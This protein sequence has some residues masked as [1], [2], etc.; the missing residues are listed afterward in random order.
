MDSSQLYYKC[1]RT[2]LVRHI[3]QGR[4]RILDV[5]CAEGF[6]GQNL[7]QLGLASEVVGIEYV[8]D[9]AKSA[10]SKLDRV[11]C[12]DIELMNRDEMGLEAES[13]DYIIC[14][15]VLEHLRDPWSVLSWLV[16]RLK[17]GG[18]VIASLP[19]VRH[20]SVL[21]PLLLKGE[22]EYQSRGIMDRTHLRFFTRKSSV[23]LIKQSGL[24]IETCEA[25]SYRKLD[26]LILG[27]TFG[28]LEGFTAIQWLITA[29]KGII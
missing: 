27:I 8:S 17:P 13:F 5:G 11:I 1:Q 16:T 2:E 26:K 24:T 21:L 28:R 7:R 6:L 15:D 29:K 3:R 22:W 12:G 9:A 23:D 4:N 10:G 14:G 20:W 18:G 19:N 25:I